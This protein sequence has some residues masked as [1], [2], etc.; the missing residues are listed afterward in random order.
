[1][2]LIVRMKN[3]EIQKFESENLANTVR[4]L[5]ADAA[6]SLVKAELPAAAVVLLRI[7]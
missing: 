2:R 3:G 5:G 6:I 1:M 4:T 7:K